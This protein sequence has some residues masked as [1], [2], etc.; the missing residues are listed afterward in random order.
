MTCTWLYWKST[1]VPGSTRYLLRRF[2]LQ[3]PALLELGFNL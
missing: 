2:L 3:G 1:S